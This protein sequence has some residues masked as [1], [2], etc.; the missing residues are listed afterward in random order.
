MACTEEILQQLYEAQ[1]KIATGSNVVKVVID[2]EETSFG[3]GNPS[4]LSALI[5]GCESYLGVVDTTSSYFTFTTSKGFG[6]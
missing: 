3:V 2:G 5:A 1:R 4:V 6:A